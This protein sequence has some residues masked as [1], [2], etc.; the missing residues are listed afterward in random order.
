[1]RRIAL[2]CFVAA[3][4]L[5]LA[6]CTTVGALLGNEVRFTAPQLQSYL[7]RRFP[8]DY[9]QLGG[10]VTL[11]V[12][13]PRLTIPRGSDRLQMDFDV[14]IGGFGMTSGTVAGHVALQSGLRF[15][16]QTRGLHLSEPALTDV[17]IPVL[18]GR[19]GDTTRGALNQWLA[20]YAREEPVYR[21]DDNAWGRLAGRTIGETTID[22]GMVTLHLQ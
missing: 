12:M 22:D 5:L 15:D 6:A 2:P 1:M 21:L 17:D 9:D 16:P 3:F 14:G 13:H 7:D 8:R 11:R 20:D 19:M 18:G 10:L 4:A